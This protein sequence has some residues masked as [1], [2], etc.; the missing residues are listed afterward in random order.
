VITSPPEQN[1]NL[2]LRIAHEGNV[3]QTGRI[4]L[5]GGATELRDDPRI[6]EAY[7]GGAAAA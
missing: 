3:L 1:E 2:A 5:H 7:L 6:R 4:V